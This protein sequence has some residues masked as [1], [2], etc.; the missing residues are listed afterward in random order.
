MEWSN[1]GDE[2]M[3]T[4]YFDRL[5]RFIGW[6]NPAADFWFVGIEEAGTWDDDEK[7]RKTIRGEYSPKDGYNPL[8]W[9][10]GQRRPT[11]YNYMSR[12]VFGV[13]RPVGVAGH[14]EY[15][16]RHLGET[17]FH[18]NRYPLAKK[19]VSD[20]FPVHYQSLF[21]FGPQDVQGR[22]VE[23]VRTARFPMLSRFWQRHQPKVTVCFGQG[24]DPTHA[25]SI[26]GIS[27]NEAPTVLPKGI[28]LYRKKGSLIFQTP[29]LGPRQLS[30]TDLDP[31]IAEAR[32][33][34]LG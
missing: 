8:E 26:F 9:V 19:R 13:R 5:N 34:S 4:E 31:V 33:L 14:L 28:R 30:Y 25:A 15:R 16:D 7:A 32:R 29:F 27:K 12:I 24:Y 2:A 21:G 1:M 17:V 20:P 18:M 3:T 22:Y 6:G 23:E 10:H 11:I